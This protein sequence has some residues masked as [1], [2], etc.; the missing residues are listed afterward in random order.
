MINRNGNSAGIIEREKRS[1][2]SINGRP[3]FI[4]A[5]TE[6]KPARRIKHRVP[7]RFSRLINHSIIRLG[8]LLVGLILLLLTP[9]QLLGQDSS[10]VFS[11]IFEGRSDIPQEAGWVEQVV[12]LT[13]R[14]VL[15]ALLAAILAFRPRKALPVLNRNPYVKQTQILLAVVGAA[16]MMIVSDNAVRAFG[17][18]AATSLIRFRTNIRDQ[19][20]ITVLL[21]NLAIG[22]AAGVGRWDLAIMLCLFVLLLL[23][24]L[25]YHEARQVFRAMQL[26]VKTHDADK[27]DEVLRELFERHNISAELSELDRQDERSPVGKVVY[28]ADLSANIDT[29][30]LSEEIFSADSENIDSIEWQQKKKASSYVYH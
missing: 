28:R 23:M 18:F 24:I 17:I 25:E 9:R 2:C 22:L 15:A 11:Q 27:T 3:V 19:K 26:K 12:M 14:L 21:I 6:P 20:E 8:F 1:S 16:L 5:R 13:F 10:S 30:G 4:P 29:D 7:G